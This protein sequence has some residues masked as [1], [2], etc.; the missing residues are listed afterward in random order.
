MGEVDQRAPVGLTVGGAQQPRPVPHPV[1]ALGLVEGVD[2]QQHLPLGLLGA[3]G[4]QGGAAP[5]AAL[6]LGVGP[7]VVE[8]PAAVGDGG[9]AVGGV[10]DLAD[11]LLEGRGE[12]GV[13]A[14][15][16][17]RVE[18]GLGAGVALADPVQG[19]LA[20]DLLEPGVG[21]GGSV[22]GG[23]GGAG[24]AGTAHRVSLKAVRVRVQA[25]FQ[26]AR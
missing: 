25:V 16:G 9:D 7:Q 19:L 10:E 26:A 14:G 23:E 6:V 22:S 24:L 17:D 12:G 13:R 5:Q 20:R 18:L 4:V 21:V 8:V 3:V 1:L 15:V 11:V 2:V